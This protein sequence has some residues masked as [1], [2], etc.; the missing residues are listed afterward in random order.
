MRC[1]G[2]KLGHTRIA[3]AGAIFARSSAA[4]APGNR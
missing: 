4:N 3:H 1:G 2:M